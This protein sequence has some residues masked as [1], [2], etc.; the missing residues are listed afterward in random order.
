MVN[1][2]LAKCV[3]PNQKNWTDHL[4]QIAFCFNASVQEA[5]KY[6]PFFLMYGTEPIWGVEFQIN[7]E[8]TRT[9]YSMNDYADLLVNRLEKAHEIVRTHLGTAAAG[10]KDWYNKKVH[11]QFFEVGDEVYVLNLRFYKGLSP[12][13]MRHYSHVA[14]VMKRF[15]NVT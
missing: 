13:W 12:K 7:C 11:T 2:M 5:T 6:T 1:S 3:S 9:A 4:Q 10:I 15:N 8:S 14:T